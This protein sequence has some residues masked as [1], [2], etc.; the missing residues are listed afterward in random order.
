MDLL[1]E[2]RVVVEIKS[3]ESVSGTHVAQVL[4]YL[5]LSGTKIGLIINFNVL[6]LVKGVKRVVAREEEIS[7]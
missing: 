3:V 5:K 2:N 7:L 4:T 1:V 6:K